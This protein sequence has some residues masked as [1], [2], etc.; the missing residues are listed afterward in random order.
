[1]LRVKEDNMP[2]SVY[3]IITLVGTS[4]KS[5]EEAAT[6]AVETAAKTLRDLRIAEVEELD[7]QIEKGKVINYRAKVRVSFKYEGS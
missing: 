7:M 3:K 2:D 1:L 4:P 6:K 5:W